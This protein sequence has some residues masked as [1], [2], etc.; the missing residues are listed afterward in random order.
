MRSHHMV[1]P[2]F[3]IKLV[4]ELQKKSK[5]TKHF[6]NINLIHSFLIRKKNT[7]EVFTCDYKTMTL[8]PLLF[9][10]LHSVT[11]ILHLHFE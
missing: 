3:R 1:V 7:T 4:N 8:L 10:F 5:A 9:F 6:C 2:Q 11:Y